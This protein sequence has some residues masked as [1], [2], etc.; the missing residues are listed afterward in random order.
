MK[1]PTSLLELVLPIL[2]VAPPVRALASPSPAG[3][4]VPIST[5]EIR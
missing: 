3:A 2:T 1:K 5:A 4:A